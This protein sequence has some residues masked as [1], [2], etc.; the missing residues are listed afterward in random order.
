MTK[1][2][3]VILAAGASSRFFPLNEQHK[4]YVTVCGKSL[5]GQTILDLL[6]H[7][8]QNIVVVVGATDPEAL[9]LRRLLDKDGVTAEIKIATQEKPTGAAGAIQ[10]AQPFIQGPF[11]I[12][13]PYYPQAGKWAE[14]LWEVYQESEAQG[15]LLASEVSYPSLYGIL[16]YEGN[17][18]LELVEKPTKGTEPSNLRVRS[19]YLFHQDLF[20]YLDEA[21]ESEY[22]FEAAY[23]QMAQDNIITFK[24]TSDTDTTLKYP[25]HLLELKDSILDS[26]VSYTSPDSSIA[27]TAI[28]DDSDGAIIIE[29]GARVGDF[30]KIVGPAF[31]GRNVWVGDY[32]FVRHSSLEMD[33]VVGA[34][35]E[36]VRSLILEE[37]S[38]HFAYLADSILGVG[39][40]VGAG[41]ISANKRFDRRSILVTVKG[42]KVDS[43]RKALGIITGKN[44]QLGIQSGSMPGSVLKS[45]LIIEPGQ[46]I[47]GTLS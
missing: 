35:T 1:P 26:R 44:V 7:D 18:V 19:I 22:S 41:F 27:E 12:T 16:R 15:V 5:I 11:V 25:W 33:S 10:A 20:K 39:T 24:K 30:A 45:E 32:A 17:R 38:I 40:T 9:E 23:S 42:E 28:L 46:H 8:F 4:G 6:A 14:E 31:I 13:S 43:H 2:T 34:K 3:A 37:S 29:S 21:P 36:V 47:N